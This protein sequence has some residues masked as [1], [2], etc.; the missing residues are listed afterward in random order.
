MERRF[1]VDL[2]YCW[3]RRITAVPWAS[4]VREPFRGVSV[5]RSVPYMFSIWAGVRA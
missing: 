1:E 4:S 5:R 3:G 2:V